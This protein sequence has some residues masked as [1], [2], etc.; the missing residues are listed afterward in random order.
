LE[1]VIEEHMQLIAERIAPETDVYGIAAV[2]LGGGYGRGE[3]GAAIDRDGNEGLHN[4]YD[5]FVITDN[6]SFLK[7]RRLKHF[8]TDVSREFTEK[9]GIDVDFSPPKNRREL[10]RMGF[11]MMWQELRHGH[12]VIVGDSKI[13]DLLPDYDIRRMPAIEGVRLMLNR[14]AGLLFCK[15]KIA[16]GKCDHESLEF[17]RR[18]IYKAWNACG[19]ICLITAENYHWSYAERLNILE[20]YR[21]KDEL[22]GSFFEQYRESVQYKLQPGALNSTAEQLKERLD[23]AICDFEKFNLRI[24]WFWLNCASDASNVVY[25]E[26]RR[27]SGGPERRSFSSIVKNMILNLLKIGLRGFTSNYC[28]KHPRYRLFSA[29]PLLLFAKTKKRVYTTTVLGL[30]KSAGDDEQK[31][32]FIELWNRF[33]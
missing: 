1:Q 13:L 25:D 23:D 32:R 33:N 18:N 29:M 14:G 16:Q 21:D 20:G 7:K 2:I 8:L 22:V 24:L 12:K 11:N 31:K 27:T 30:N 10:S 19:D 26:L 3:G 28:F 17:I 15:E 4:D 5:F 6:I 9:I